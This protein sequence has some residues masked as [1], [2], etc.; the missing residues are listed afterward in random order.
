[1]LSIY[2]LL[3]RFLK[4]NTFIILIFFLISSISLFINLYTPF[5]FGTFIDKLLQGLPSKKKASIY[6]YTCIIAFLTGLN[7]LLDYLNTI[8]SIRLKTKISFGLN[9]DL[10][11]HIK[12]L[13]LSF[14]KDFD[15]FK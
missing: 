9:F 15:L 6:N 8:L 10:L 14:F 11:E 12:K 3:K 5:I 7:L 13:P 2:R 4:E 1:M